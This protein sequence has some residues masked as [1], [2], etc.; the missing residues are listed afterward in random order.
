MS[1]DCVSRLEADGDY[2]HA[3]K[4]RDWVA[5]LPDGAVITQIIRDFGNQ[6]DPELRLVGLRASWS[7]QR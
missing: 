1:I 6:R 4:V 5:D 3:K 7:E 2:L